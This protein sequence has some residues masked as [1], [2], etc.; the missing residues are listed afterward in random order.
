MLKYLTQTPIS[1]LRIPNIA[2]QSP[3][4]QSDQISTLKEDE[5]EGKKRG[6]FHQRNATMLRPT[7]LK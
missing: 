4:V 6:H 3:F 5:E 7:A 1:P 2:N